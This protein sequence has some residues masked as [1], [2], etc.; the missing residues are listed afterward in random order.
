MLGLDPQ[1]DGNKLRQR[2]GIQLQ[3]EKLPDRIKVWE[4]MEL[5]ASF[6]SQSRPLQP[7]LDELGLSDKTNAFFETL[8]GGQ[9]QRLYIALSMVGD[10]EIVYLDELTTGLDPQ[11]RRAMWSLIQNIC[12]RGKTVV[13]ITH[14]MEEAERLC[15]RVAIVDKGSIIALD[16]LPN[17]VKGLD[18]GFQIQFSVADTSIKT[19]LEKVIGRVEQNGERLIL[20]N[21]DDRAISEVINILNRNNV[22]FYDFS[23]KQ[24]NLEDVFLSLTGDRMRD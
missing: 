14:F 7:I 17:L 2:V 1:R 15:D 19:E 6:Y 8:S 10:P 23:V 24:P 20:H 18:T 5:F 3:E 13:L 21:R 11:A 9:K 4:A 16:T 22:Q 12:H